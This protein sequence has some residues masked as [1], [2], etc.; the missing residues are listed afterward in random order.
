[1]KYKNILAKS[2]SNF[3]YK[4]KNTVPWVCLIESFNGEEIVGMFYEKQLQ[5]E[6][7]KDFRVKKLI[8]RKGDKLYVK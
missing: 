7:Q 5:T 8:K 3:C 2:Y 6:N 4:N 1:M